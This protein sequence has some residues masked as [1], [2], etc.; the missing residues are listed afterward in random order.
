MR[1]HIS[2]DAERELDEIGQ[3]IALD[4]PDRAVS[5]V[6]ELVDQCLALSDQPR[7]YPIAV[8]TKGLQLRR[9]IYRGYLIFY[10]V[11]DHVEV[12]HVFHGSRDYLKVLFPEED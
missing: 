2:D 6:V 11:T 4:N 8:E 9:C 5:F 7:R 10:A 12:A 3:Y 1:V